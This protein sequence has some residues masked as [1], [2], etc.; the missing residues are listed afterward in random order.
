MDAGLSHSSSTPSQRAA[1]QLTRDQASQVPQPHSGPSAVSVPVLAP[2]LPV[3]A[4]AWPTQ[5][6]M[7]AA[8]SPGLPGPDSGFCVPQRGLWHGRGAPRVCLPSLLPIPGSNMCQLGAVDLLGM[9]CLQSWPHACT[10]RCYSLAPLDLLRAPVLQGSGE[11]RGS[12]WIGP[13]LLPALC[14]P[15]SHRGEP[16]SPLQTLS[17]ELVLMG[18]GSLVGAAAQPALAHPSLL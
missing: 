14:K 2:H 1:L 10:S 4:K 3:S 16:T 11:F 18:A 8:A 12:A 13:P 7:S 9:V 6:L 17:P 15:Q 5:M